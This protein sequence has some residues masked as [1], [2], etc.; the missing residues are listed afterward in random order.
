MG[1]AYSPDGLSFATAG[2]AVW[3]LWDATT[4]KHVTRAPGDTTG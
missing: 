3:D 2:G 4:G 1:I